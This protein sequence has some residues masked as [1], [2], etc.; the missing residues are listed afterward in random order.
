MTQPVGGDLHVDQVL[1]NFSVAWVQGTNDFISS[2]VFP[3]LPVEKRTDR[4]RV[5]S[6]AQHRNVSGVAKRAPGTES[7][8]IGWTHTHD[9]YHV[10]PFAVHVDLDDQ[11]MAEADNPLEIPREATELI[12]QRLLLHKEL[13]WHQQFFKT[14]V[15]ATEPTPD[16]Q[17]NDVASDPIGDVGK[18]FDDFARLNSKAP[19]TMVIGADVWRALKDHPD[20]VDRIKYTQRG[21]VTADLIAAAF[22]I[23][24]I[25]V[26]R[27]T[28]VSNFEDHGSAKEDDLAAAQF[29]YVTN[30]KSVLLTYSTGTPKKMEPLG[31]LSITWKGYFAGNAQGVRIKRFRQEA[32]E[33]D[34]IEGMITYQHKL[35]D[36]KMGVFIG[37]LVA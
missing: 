25:L 5:Y 13:D 24:N 4:Y 1:T 17:W 6:R 21:L 33:S 8:G 23:P 35:V 16:E 9:T 3:R 29:S 11:T 19:N 34:R 31:G 12:T 22:E 30:P 36:N 2:K 28:W 10:D 14:G 7:R 32:I 27:A 37:N 15:W 18:W 26:S 20:L